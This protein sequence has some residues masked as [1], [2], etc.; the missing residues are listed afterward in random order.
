[1]RIHRTLLVAIVALGISMLGWA[2]EK[3]PEDD[4]IVHEWGTFTSMQGSDAVTLEGLHHEEEAL[5]AFVYARSRMRL[6]GVKGI[7]VPI[8]HVTEKMETPVTYFY[9]EKGLRVR[10]RVVF[11]HG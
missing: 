10:A 4:L 3:A 9:S 7:S 11:N 6:T 2:H 1:M 5:P 8:L